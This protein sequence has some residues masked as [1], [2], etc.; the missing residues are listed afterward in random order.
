MRP[1]IHEDQEVPP[2]RKALERAE[3]S[4]AESSLSGRTAAPLASCGCRHLWRVLPYELSLEFCHVAQNTAHNQGNHNNQSSSHSSHSNHKLRLRHPVHALHLASQWDTQGTVEAGNQPHAVRDAT[5]WYGEEHDRT[6]ASQ[7]EGI[8]E[9][10]HP[11]VQTMPPVVSPSDKEAVLQAA[12]AAAAGLT[13][14]PAGDGNKQDVSSNNIVVSGASASISTAQTEKKDSPDGNTVLQGKATS[15]GTDTS[16]QEAPP[17]LT[18]VETLSQTQSQNPSMKVDAASRTTHVKAAE[19]ALSTPSVVPPE[20]KS[21]SQEKQAST[22]STVAK[23]KT[24][25]SP[26]VTSISAPV[27]PADGAAKTM[28]QESDKPSMSKE[29]DAPKDAPMQMDTATKLDLNDT[30]KITTTTISPA[31]PMEVDAKTSNEDSSST[32]PTKPAN[33]TASHKALSEDSTTKNVNPDDPT[34]TTIP[35]GDSAAKAE[36]VPSCTTVVPTTTTTT[37]ITTDAA[38]TQ[39]KPSSIAADVTMSDAKEATVKANSLPGPSMTESASASGNSTISKLPTPHVATTT[40][41]TTTTTNSDTQYLLSDAEFKFYQSKEE[42]VNMLRRTLLSKRIAV[43]TTRKGKANHAANQAK[44]RKMEHRLSEWLHAPPAAPAL[45]PLEERYYMTAM[46]K[47]DEQVANWMEHFRLARKTYWRRQRTAD[48]SS[49]PRRQAAAFWGTVPFSS[50]SRNE[51]LTSESNGNQLLLHCLDSHFI[52]TKSQMREHM[53]LKGYRLGVCLNASGKL[54]CFDCDDFIQHEIFSRELL[55]LDLAEKLPWLSWA[56]QPVHRSFDAMR[57]VDIPEVGIVWNGMVAAYP[58]TV[59]SYHLEASTRCHRR[60]FSFAGEVDALQDPVS[61][62]VQTF[63]ALQ[64]SFHPMRRFK[65]A[66]PVGIYNLGDT[67]FQS[68]VFQCILN[69]GPVQDYFLKVGHNHLAVPLYPSLSSHEKATTPQSPPQSTPHV[70]LASEL[71][72]MFLSYYSSSIGFDV[73]K[74]LSARPLEDPV[75]DLTR[76]QGEPISAAE[77]LAATWKCKDLSHLAGYGQNDAH[78]FLHGFLDVVQKHI[79][80]Y[81]AAVSKALAKSN[82][83]KVGLTL[84]DMHHDSQST[85]IIKNL[86]EGKLRSVLLC[87]ECGEKRKQS[88]SFLSIS[89]PLSKEVHKATEGR[90]G[91]STEGQGRKLSVERQL[92][93]FTMP[94]SLSGIDCPACQKKTS[95]IKQHVVSRLPKI[96]CLHL[97][98]FDDKQKINDFVSFPLKNLNMGSLLPQF[99][100]VTSFGDWDFGE[101]KNTADL[102]DLMTEAELPYDLFATVNHFGTLQSGHYMANVLVEH[103]WYHCNDAHVSSISEQDVLSDAAYILFYAR[104]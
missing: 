63:A 14:V 25:P 84:R 36:P 29:S 48:P 60:L 99:C 21:D 40:T 43:P 70:C 37:T 65:I 57:F 69:C 89:L 93:H 2:F 17:N 20:A 61:G 58:S 19:T 3:A 80:R 35:T 51:N 101:N 75:V 86:F 6:L 5:V 10:W 49:Q 79:R 54:Y 26:E 32:V 15:G 42:Q 59:P 56:D 27:T 104:R 34:T 41:T 78:E 39:E 18:K 50:T 24:E 90:P 88:E 62:A 52:G 46:T 55:R 87:T 16:V 83:S 74:A 76:I 23:E 47:A 67:C 11:L 94:E 81:R 73:T 30:S 71:D 1:P 100:E 13:T 12:A 4:L 31:V 96:L 33:D 102:A 66:K 38:V 92:R 22:L 45:S 85:D 95:T 68:A 77:M 91:E 97:K 44:K 72:K 9:V 28:S 53:A 8:V 7:S 98:R 103:Q 82:T 64:R